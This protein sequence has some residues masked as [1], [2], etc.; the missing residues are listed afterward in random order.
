MKIYVCHF[1]TM[2]PFGVSKY[3]HERKNNVEQSHIVLSPSNQITRHMFIDS[4]LT[5]SF[6]L[7]PVQIKPQ[8]GIYTI[9][10]IVVEEKSSNRQTSKTHCSASVVFL[11]L[12]KESC[13]F[14]NDD[15][16][17]FRHI[18]RSYSHFSLGIYQNMVGWKWFFTLTEVMVLNAHLSL[19]PPCVGV[20]LTWPQGPQRSSTG[21]GLQKFLYR[22]LGNDTELSAQNR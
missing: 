2:Y 16:T 13:R 7:L 18:V 14:F 12:P 19:Q 22:L 3:F 5:S 17:S 11:T 1:V 21:D 9:L 10:F 6:C 8:T 20:W 4:V 15:M